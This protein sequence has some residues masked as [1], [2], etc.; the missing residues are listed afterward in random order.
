MAD[1]VASG[2]AKYLSQFSDVTTLLGSFSLSDPNVSLRGVPWLFNSNLLV[3]LKGTRQAALVLSDFGTWT[4]PLQLSG[5]R[6]RRLKVDI[7]QDAQRDIEGN[8]IQTDAATNNLVMHIFNAL[9]LRLQRRDNDTVIW[10][11]MV[12]YACQVIA[13][14]MA[15]RIPDGDW[16]MLGTAVYGVSFSGWTDTLS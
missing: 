15:S 11:D 5:A 2:A 1:D 12:T 9:H 6:N 7:Y 13:E 4:A 8:I 10:G 3:N 16:G 14:P